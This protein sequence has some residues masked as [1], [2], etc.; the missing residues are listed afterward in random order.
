MAT[1]QPVAGEE[2][3]EHID[4]VRGYALLGVL[5]M[6]IQYWF[7]NPPQPYWLGDH[8]FS[9]SL[10]LAADHLLRIWFEAKSVTLFSM[11]FAIG[12]CIQRERV[13]DKGLSWGRYATRRLLAMLLFGILH[14]TLIWNGDI[15]H[16]YALMGLITLPFL[17]RSQK[18]IAWWLGSILGLAALLMVGFSLAQALKAAPP[19]MG[20][21]PGAPALR[22]WA[23][24]CIQG[25]QNT[26]WLEVMRFRVWDYQR[27]MWSPLMGFF[28]IFTLVNYLIG[29]WAWKQGALREPQA[30]RRTLGRIAVLFLL[31]GLAMGVVEDFERPI[32]AWVR[33][34]WAY[35]RWALPWLSLARL[36]PVQ[37]MGIGL[38]SGLMWLWTAPERPR[39][40]QPF[41]YVGRMAFTNY[42]LQS[43]ICTTTFYGWGF[44][45]YNKV[46]PAQGMA[47]GLLVFGL[48][49]PLSRWWLSRFAY[50]PLEWVWRCL[51]YGAR[52][53]FRRAS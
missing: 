51:T 24:A 50:G 13:L 34:H 45:L 9:G 18:T 23:Q 33:G 30:H 21:N 17:G 16:L 46:G 28:F 47:F 8:P 11:L 42:I 52:Q 25:Y 48:Q 1:A 39:W 22:A 14:I 3:L 32:Q 41:T 6:N 27:L 5:L 4:L 40:L 12:L 35:G 53:P 20:S 2:R 49:I 43:L 26:S 38:A 10:N 44:G 15:L 29:M 37:I 31:M 36:V 7:R 19:A